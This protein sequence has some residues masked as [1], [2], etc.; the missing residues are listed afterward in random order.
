MSTESQEQPQDQHSQEAQS[1]VDTGEQ[2]QQEQE[3]SREHGPSR[4]PEP[5]RE[6]ERQSAADNHGAGLVVESRDWYRDKFRRVTL[7]CL[8]LVLMLAGSLAVNVVQGVMRPTPRYFA[9]TDNLRIEKMRPLNKPVI[10]QSGLLSWTTRK[11][12]ETFSLDFVHW[13][14]K[15]MDVKP[16]YTEKAFRQLIGSLKDSGN[17]KMLKRKKLVMSSTV[18]RSPVVKAK[19]VVSGRMTWKI[20]FPIKIAYESSQRVISSQKLMC[21]VMV[22]RVPTIEYPRG[23]KIQ[24]IVLK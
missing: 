22:R 4:I 14:E 1:A 11:V 19:G 20:E 18:Q 8:I 2:S 23:I 10:S 16:A 9:V 7:I 21:N 6:E 24:Q 5:T 17:L 12:T 15:L 13:R 3:Q